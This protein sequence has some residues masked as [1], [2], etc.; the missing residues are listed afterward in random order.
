MVEKFEKLVKQVFPMQQ[1]ETI[2]DAIL[3][4]EKLDD[5]STLVRL[6]TKN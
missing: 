6:L 4:L 2:R 3:G 5:A 1:V